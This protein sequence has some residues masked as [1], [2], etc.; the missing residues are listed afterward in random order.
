MIDLYNEKQSQSVFFRHLVF[1]R[2]Q[3]NDGNYWCSLNTR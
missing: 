1:F 2:S 3:L